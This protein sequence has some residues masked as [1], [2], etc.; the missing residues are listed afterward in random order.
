MAAS[1]EYESLDPEKC[2]CSRI[3][4]EEKW[5]SGTETKKRHQ[6]LYKKV[7]YLAIH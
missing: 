4:G 5:D 6:N 1:L 2:C 7:P 3:S